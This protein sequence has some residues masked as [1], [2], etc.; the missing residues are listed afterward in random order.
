MPLDVITLALSAS[1]RDRSS[2]GKT[3]LI[4]GGPGGGKMTLAAQLARYLPF[5]DAV[6]QTEDAVAPTI[7]KLRALGLDAVTE[8][9]LGDTRRLSACLVRF[10]VEHAPRARV[11]KTVPFDR[12]PA[13]IAA[14]FDGSVLSHNDVLE[15]RDHAGRNCMSIVTARPDEMYSLSE[16]FDIVLRVREDHYTH[17]RIVSLSENRL[18]IEATTSRYELTTRGFELISG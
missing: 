15:L 16:L 9:S 12:V 5:G 11:S 1:R 17:Q 13:P 6:W 18:G 10:I 7:R 14:V 8:E 4:V 2:L 3:I